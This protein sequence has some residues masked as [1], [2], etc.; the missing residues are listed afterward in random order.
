MQPLPIQ[1][2]LFVATWIHDA[3]YGIVGK[4]IDLT[5]LL[6]IFTDN[7][8]GAAGVSKL[9]GIFDLALVPMCSS[10]VEVGPCFSN[11]GRFPR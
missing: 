7:F 11:L 8:Y 10:S 4:V 9:K 5:E 2:L 1:P 6:S 3:S